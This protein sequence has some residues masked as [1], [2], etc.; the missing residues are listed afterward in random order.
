MDYFLEFNS[1]SP[2]LHACVIDWVSD[3]VLKP[4]K[5]FD[6]LPPAERYPPPPRGRGGAGARSRVCGVS[7]DLCR[8][9]WTVSG[10]N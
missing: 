9:S 3:Y 1:N 8:E 2:I 5:E 10:R 7:G 4:P 6:P